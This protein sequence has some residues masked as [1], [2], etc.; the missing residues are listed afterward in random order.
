[1]RL[2]FP[3]S[4]LLA[5]PLCE[6]VGAQPSVNQA[7]FPELF[8]SLPPG[9]SRTSS[10]VLAQICG[11]GVAPPADHST[12]RRIRPSFPPP[13]ARRSFPPLLH[14]WCELGARMVR[15]TLLNL[16]SAGNKLFFRLFFPRVGFWP[17][18]PAV[19]LQSRSIPSPSPGFLCSP[20]FRPHPST[21]PPLSA[22]TPRFRPPSNW[23]SESTCYE[24][25]GRPVFTSGLL[26][27]N[28]VCF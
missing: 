6:Q 5:S 25:A 2:F 21:F 27:S 16:L 20:P 7:V 13:H 15:W 23:C 28:R 18:A 9:P 24:P 22:T 17:A 3:A 26:L 12:T 4:S 14:E 19:K 10:L 1:L 8:S 11:G